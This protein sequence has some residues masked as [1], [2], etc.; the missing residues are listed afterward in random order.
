MR[1]LNAIAIF[2]ALLW[3][4]SNFVALGFGSV[5]LIGLLAIVDLLYYLATL[6]YLAFRLW[7][8]WRRNTPFWNAR[9]VQMANVS[10]ISFAIIALSLWAGSFVASESDRRGDQLIKLIQEFRVNNGRLPEDLNELKASGASIPSPMILNSDFRYSIYDSEFSVA[11][12]STSWRYCKN[13]SG[14]PGWGCTD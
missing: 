2:I 11:Y 5:A 12:E 14:S 13:F 8:S 3:A 10:V 1:F 7:T 6:L 4:A 9:S